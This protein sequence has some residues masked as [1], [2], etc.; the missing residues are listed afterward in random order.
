ML[1]PELLHVLLDDEIVVV[2]ERMAARGVNAQRDGARVLVQARDFGPNRV[3][4]LEAATYDGDPVGVYF[5]DS[6]GGL[7][8]GSEWPSGLYG[9]EHP[10]LHR[11][12]ACVRGTLDYHTHPSHVNDPWERYRGRIRLPELIHHLLQRTAV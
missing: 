5:T 12:F 3:L 10:V 4:M 6:D 7:L 2:N 8:R 11:P 9:G 1:H